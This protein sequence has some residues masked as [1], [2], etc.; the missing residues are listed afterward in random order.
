MMEAAGWLNVQTFSD[1]DA[2]KTAYLDTL[3][4][5]MA[6]EDAVIFDAKN[7]TP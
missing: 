1:C 3:D 7:L 4:S 6:A 2:I 5:K